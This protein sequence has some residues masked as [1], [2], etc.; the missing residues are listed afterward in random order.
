MGLPITTQGPGICF[1]FPDVCKTQVGPATV[2]LPYPNIGQLS[3]AQGVASSVLVGGKAVVTSNSS[4]STTTGDE[5]GAV[6]GVVSG[7]T[8][9]E[10]KF[11]TFSATVLAEGGNVVRLSDT[12][13]QNKGNAVGQVLGGNPTVL[14]G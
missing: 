4:I 11:V 6:G 14:V 3:D 7:V 12:T 5:A 9:G 8:K 2:P 13:T 1:A 10:V